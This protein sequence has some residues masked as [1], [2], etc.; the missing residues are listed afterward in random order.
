MARIS[1]VDP[2]GHP[3]LAPLVERVKGSRR[4]KV[5]NVYRLLMHSPKLA[6]T[7]FEHLN[8]VRWA[9]ALSGRLREIVIIRIGYLNSAAYILKQHIPKLATA[10]GLSEAEC[11]ALADWRTSESFSDLERAALGLTDEL[12]TKAA[13]SDGAFAEVRRHFGERETL[14]LTVLISTYNMHSRVMNALAI[15]LEQD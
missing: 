8:A 1:L 4:G 15:D 10:E 11:R 14:E 3:E 6:E 13:A 7:W 9:T 12:T 5:I 2:D